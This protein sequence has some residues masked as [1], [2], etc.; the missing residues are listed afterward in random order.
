MRGTL[1]LKLVLVKRRPTFLSAAQLTRDV[2]NASRV[3]SRG[4]ATLEMMTDGPGSR[5]SRRIDQLQIR[6]QRRWLR[7]LAPHLAI[8]VALCG[9]F[10][11]SAS[12]DD[13]TLER[14]ANDPDVA[15]QRW[16]KLA[17]DP[18]DRRQWTALLHSLGQ[19]RVRQRIE[20]E[21]A[22]R[23]DDANWRILDA[24]MHLARGDATTA[25]A[26]L[27]SI[28]DARGGTRQELFNLRIEAWVAANRW[29]DALAALERRAEL[30][31]K[32]RA[33]LLEQAY[34]LAE[35]AQRDEDAVRLAQRLADLASHAPASELRLAR[36]AARAR[37]PD[38]ADAAYANAI[39]TATSPPDRDAWIAEQAQ[40]RLAADRADGAIE[41]IWT[42]L[43]DPQRGRKADRARWWMTL[44]LAH[45]QRHTAAALDELASWLSHHTH[46]VDGWRALAVMQQAAGVDASE[47]WRSVLA[48]APGDREAYVALIDAAFVRG[49][50]EAA[51]KLAETF[52]R[53][54]PDEVEIGL[55]LAHRFATAGRHDRG[56]AL[57]Q[58]IRAHGA[59]NRRTQMLL[60]DFFNLSGEPDIALEVAETLADRYPRDAD[61]CVALGEQLYQL[62]RINEAIAEWE[63]LP[64]LIR[65]RHRGFAQLAEI[66][67]EHERTT[68]AVDSIK[69][70]MTMAPTHPAY[71]RMRAVLA[72]EQRRPAQALRLWEQVYAATQEHGE[73]VLLRD[74][75]RTRIVELL[76]GGVI[77]QR[78]ARLQQSIVEATERLQRGTPRA[79]SVEAGR[80]L[81]ELF[82]RQENYPAAVK[83]QE[84]LLALD[85]D[86]PQHLDDLAAAQRRAGQ[87]EAALATLERLL[88]RDPA[89]GPEVLATMSELAFEAGD[90]A[91]ALRAATRAAQEDHDQV[92][93]LVRL[94]E[95]HERKGELAPAAAAYARALE[96]AP[97]EGRAYLRLAELEV[98]R[99]HPERA[100]ELLRGLLETGGSPDTLREAGARAL[101]V[102]ESMATLEEVLSLAVAQAAA[103]PQADAPR[104]FLLEALERMDPTAVRAWMDADT[105][106]ARAHALR[107]PLIDALARG[108]VKTRLRA[109]EH[110]G[111]LGLPETAVPLL[112]MAASLMPPRDATGAVREMFHRARRAA[113]HAAAQL[114]EPDAVPGL[115]A[116]LEQRELPDDLRRAAAWGLARA[117]L[118][119]STTALA[120]HL[121][122]PEDEAI[123]TMA[124]VA[125]ALRPR[126][127]VPP[128]AILEVQALAR[129]TENPHL[130]HACTFAEAAL[131]P[132]ETVEARF[133]RA[134][135]VSDPVVAAIAAW[136][137][138]RMAPPSPAVL[139]A[140]Y[141]SALG[142]FGLPRDA[143]LASLVRIA[144]PDALPPDDPPV[145]MDLSDAH[146]GTAIDRWLRQLVVPRVDPIPADALKSTR[147]QLIAA[148]EDAK[149]GTDAE[150]RAARLAVEA[151]GS[152]DG[153][154][155]L[156]WPGWVIGPLEFGHSPN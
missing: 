4:D 97:G 116:L 133:L 82:T 117:P 155:R 78:R 118:P 104:E 137:L 14:R 27:E 20:N 61:V 79:H 129:Q 148:Y 140:L 149:R 66:L 125:L 72:E 92:E 7:C 135:E 26:L 141:R 44:V 64:H 22:R 151:C 6:P 106:S 102:A 84:T 121:R 99:G 24:R 9:G 59:R 108:S 144:D 50:H 47:A 18:L 87:S 40:A 1:R 17:A 34:T 109:A 5:F 73:H 124:C 89:R 150:R 103:A 156:C 115:V 94:G 143:A 130:R 43:E 147:P 123:Q 13:W 139:R 12:A 83:V 58:W 101:D 38:L 46:D 23:P 30:Q 86:E 56:M 85:P 71:L 88:A 35:T 48:E 105:P 55:D 10:P 107:G 93:A 127:S 81:S 114:H 68:E 153:I 152:S 36:A 111:A 120:H 11:S 16:T 134:I 8:L 100:A 25:V 74:E 67:S 39:A 3:S 19:D 126:A 62:G 142:P 110:L 75:A 76:V 28:P 154:D 70:A 51:T 2:S 41:L 128:R 112:Q 45:R 31:P 33:K 131:T 146:W 69:R 37:R 52:L 91:G 80:F 145:H 42:L 95:L 138:G 63:R 113:V 119:A 21:R 29:S 60:L 98:T 65:P 32:V 132:D 90:D 15:E 122:E 96:T 77:P 53:R 54:H 49:D 136:R 57:A